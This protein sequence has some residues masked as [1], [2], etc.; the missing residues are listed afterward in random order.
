M[1]PVIFLRTASVLTLI[2]A[3]LHTVGGVFGKPLPGPASAAYAAMQANDFVVFGQTRN[4]FMFYRGMGLGVT[5]FLTFEAIV[6]WLLG[7]L[8]KSDAARLR[9]VLAVFLIAYL[10]FAVNSYVYFFPPP[11]VVEILIAACM[12]GAI[13]TAKP[14]NA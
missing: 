2:H 14:A 4:Y 13:L 12:A 1:K 3:V 6:F 7:G 8:A 10:A 11:V 9:P 5:I